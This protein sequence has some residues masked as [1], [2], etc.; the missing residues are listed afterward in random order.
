MDFLFGLL[1]NLSRKANTGRPVHRIDLSLPIVQTD[2][3]EIF[4]TTPSSQNL[5]TI[6]RQKPPLVDVNNKKKLTQTARIRSPARLKHLIGPI[7]VNLYVD[8]TGMTAAESIS[9]MADTTS[10]PLLNSTTSNRTG[11]TKHTK[12]KNVDFNAT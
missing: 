4:Y 9:T 2:S 6:S 8:M 7:Y 1:R 5:R 10:N 11:K 3:Y 12:Q